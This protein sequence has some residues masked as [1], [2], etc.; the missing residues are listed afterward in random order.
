[1][2][3]DGFD[4]SCPASAN[5]GGTVACTLT[6]T[7]DEAK[8]WPVVGILHLSSDANRAL[9]RGSP[10]DLQLETPAPA[11][12]IGGGLWWIGDVLVAY[13][14]FDWGGEASAQA[15][16]TV[17]IIIENDDD[18]EGEEIFYV[19][20]APNRSRGVGFLYT[21]RQAITISASDTKSSD[22]DLSDLKIAET[23]AQDTDSI[24]SG[25]LPPRPPTP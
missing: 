11:S 8:D 12:G 3:F 16:R 9:V 7:G 14:R 13:S 24:L 15:S 18:Y 22:A 10:L 6:N 21:N 23:D 5:E 19:S 1:M 17:S 2:S 20:L 25:F 4:L